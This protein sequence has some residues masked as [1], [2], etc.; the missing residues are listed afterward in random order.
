MKRRLTE[1]CLLKRRFVLNPIIDWSDYDVWDFLHLRNVPV[2]PM[3]EK[4]YK[5]IG[6]IGCPMST[7]ARKE[8]D[9]F[10]KYKRAYKKAAEK[11]LQHRKE[12]ADY[13]L[14]RVME[15]PETYF[16]WWLRR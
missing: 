14:D 13:P 9:K 1:I 12:I 11:Y 6:C 7:A 3:Y 8:L 15:T 4:G 5:R 2:N 10:P 16:D